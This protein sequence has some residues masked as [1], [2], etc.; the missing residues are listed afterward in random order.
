MNLGRVMEVFL[1]CYL[2]LLSTDIKKP[3][4]KTAATPWLNPYDCDDKE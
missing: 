4:N 3:G 1:F 2:V